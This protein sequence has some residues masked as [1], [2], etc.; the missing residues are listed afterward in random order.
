MSAIEELQALVHDKFGIAPADIDV[1]APMR[2]S[3]MDSLAL[4]ELLFEIEDRMHVTL[5][6][7]HEQIETLAGLA[8]AIE[9][10]RAAAVQRV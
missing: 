4:A 9:G 1:N 6:Q 5:D 7:S 3:G 10:M 8:E 2:D